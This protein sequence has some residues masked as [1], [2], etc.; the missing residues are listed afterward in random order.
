MSNQSLLPAGSSELEKKLSQTLAAISAIPVPINL[1]WQANRCPASLLPWLAWSLSVDEWDDDWNEEQKRR[2]VLNSINVHKT[3]G[4]IGSVKRA[5]NAINIDF[6]V[7]NEG[8]TH[9]AGYTIVVN[10][11]MTVEQAASLR[12]ILTDVV[13]ARCNLI[14][15]DFKAVQ[16][17]HDN[18]ITYNGKY[19]YGA[20]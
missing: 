20:A 10:T 2:A 7:I 15:I 8:V 6:T 1:L 17:L 4:T 19:N 11:P 18:K 16:W 3:K 14:K 13:P 5:L 9:W 12:K